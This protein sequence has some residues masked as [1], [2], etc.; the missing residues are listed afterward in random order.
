MNKKNVVFIILAVAIGIAPLL[1]LQHFTNVPTNSASAVVPLTAVGTSYAYIDLN[2]KG[3]NNTMSWG[4]AFIQ[5]VANFTLTSDAINLQD[6][7]ARIEFYNFHVY[8]EQ[9]SIVNMSYSLA[10]TRSTVYVPGEPLIDVGITG[11]GNNCFYFAD[12]TMY[13]GNAVLGDTKCGG[14]TCISDASPMAMRGYALTTLGCFIADYDGEKALQII[15]NIRNAQT[16][17]IE[18]SKVCSVTYRDS[19]QQKSSTTLDLVSNEV[20]G[21]IEL[22]RI[23]SGFICGT[24]VEG[25]V[26][27]PVRVPEALP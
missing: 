27:W 12:G 10:V 20:L 6:A 17:Y 18:V 21:Y 14:S 19:S 9:G 25:T 22:T 26:P 23:D 15:S 24:Y 4:G 2:V 3:G 16:I 1:S 13:D 8:S 11:S 5:V 7:D